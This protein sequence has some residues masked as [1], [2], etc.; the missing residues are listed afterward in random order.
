MHSVPCFI[1]SSF[2]YLQAL[3]PYCNGVQKLPH[4]GFFCIYLHQWFSNVNRLSE[5]AVGLVKQSARLHPQSFSFIRSG[6]GPR[7]CISNNSQVMPMLLV[8]KFTL[9]TAHLYVGY[10]SHCKV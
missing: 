9:R 1:I 8:Q 3:S 5:S 6:L 2:L 4:L 10:S 7:I